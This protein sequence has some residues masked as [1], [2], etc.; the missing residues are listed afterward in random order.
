MDEQDHL[1]WSATEFEQVIIISRDIGSLSAIT[2][3]VA[4]EAGA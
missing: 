2:A 3:A 4:V 1:H